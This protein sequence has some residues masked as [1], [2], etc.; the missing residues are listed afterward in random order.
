[1]Q[2]LSLRTGLSTSDAK[3]PMAKV[4]SRVIGRMIGE[5][6]AEAIAR[7]DAL[8]EQ[9]RTDVLIPWCQKHKLTILIG[10]GTWKFY[11]KNGEYFDGTEQDMMKPINNVLGQPGLGYGDYFGYHVESVEESDLLA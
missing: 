5:I 9:W 8:A 1:M 7:M 10:N 4:T 2:P 11:D 6:N 3:E